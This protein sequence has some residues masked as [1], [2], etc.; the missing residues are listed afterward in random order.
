MIKS[1]LSL[2]GSLRLL[3][4][5]NTGLLVML[6]LANLLVNAGLRTVSLKSAKSAV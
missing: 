1:I 2:A 6:S 4:T 5:S 3:L